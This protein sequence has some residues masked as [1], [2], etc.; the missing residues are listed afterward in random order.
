VL[1]KSEGQ[2]ARL[3]IATW[4]CRS[5]PITASDVAAGCLP[6]LSSGSDANARAARAFVSA[7]D[8]NQSAAKLAEVVIELLALSPPD[9]VDRLTWLLD[10]YFREQLLLELPLHPRLVTTFV[11]MIIA[12]QLPA[13][14][15]EL[16][17]MRKFWQALLSVSEGLTG[18]APRDEFAAFVGDKT[19]VLLA[20]AGRKG[21]EFVVAEN[22]IRELIFSFSTPGTSER[23][24]AE[25]AYFAETTRLVST[26]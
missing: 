5:A 14:A 12:S 1:D 25:H 24:I 3:R 20:R 15:T 4:N 8:L 10:I 2:L 23:A 18:A 7:S 9:V 26:S 19:A 16:D 11:A 21:L 6:S 22:R 17:D 13:S